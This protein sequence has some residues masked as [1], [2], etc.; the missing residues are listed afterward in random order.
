[1]SRKEECSSAA[2]DFEEGLSGVCAK[3]IEHPIDI[4]GP[5]GDCEAAAARVVAIRT[6][7]AVEI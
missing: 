6:Y 3:A 1:M 5:C 4:G 7:Q 2:T